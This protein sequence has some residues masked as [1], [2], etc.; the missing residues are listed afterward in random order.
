MGE[1]SCIMFVDAIIKLNL[2]KRKL[3]VKE[4]H[5]KLRRLSGA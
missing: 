2:S 3:G 4:N 1:E 5:L